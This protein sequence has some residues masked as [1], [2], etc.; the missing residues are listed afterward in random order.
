MLEVT[1]WRS[2]NGG[3]GMEVTGKS[4]VIKRPSGDPPK[5][6]AV[7]KGPPERPS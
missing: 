7:Q 6:E 2:Q 5:E 3:H 1:E 4:E